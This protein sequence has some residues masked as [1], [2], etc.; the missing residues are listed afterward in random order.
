MKL[1]YTLRAEEDLKLAMKWYEGQRAGLGYEFLDCVEYAIKRIIT[2]PESYEKPYKS[3]HRCVI[4]RFPFSLFYT[5]EADMIIIQAIFDN[6][7]DPHK[8]P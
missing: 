2:Y 1:K 7:Q 5:I 4:R 6:R 8:L 3:Y